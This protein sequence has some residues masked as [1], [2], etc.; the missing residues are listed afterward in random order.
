MMKID[1]RK[2]GSTR[3]KAEAGVTG[4][5]DEGLITEAITLTLQKEQPFV[6]V[7]LELNAQKL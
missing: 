2:L 3:D 7:W 5:R 4:R 6:G 1:L